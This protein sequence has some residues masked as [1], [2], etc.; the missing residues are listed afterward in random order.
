MNSKCILMRM[1]EIEGVDIRL[2]AEN[3]MKIFKFRNEKTFP[4]RRK[5]CLFVRKNDFFNCSYILW[6]KITIIFINL[7]EISIFISTSHLR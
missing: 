3:H 5:R 6:V 1:K 4:F 7:S 2:N